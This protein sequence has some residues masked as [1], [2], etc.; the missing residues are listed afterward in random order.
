MNVR[1]TDW[2]LICQDEV[3]FP[4]L[5]EIAGSMLGITLWHESLMW[6]WCECIP[7]TNQADLFNMPA[8]Y[9]GDF[10]WQASTIF[11]DVSLCCV[12]SALARCLSP[13]CQWGVAVE[14]PGREL[15]SVELQKQGHCTNKEGSMTRVLDW[16]LR[17]LGFL[18]YFLLWLRNLSS[19]CFWLHCSPFTK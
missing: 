1:I 3:R 11:P 8:F 4:S 12:G 17:L 2:F 5:V 16:E 18:I 13:R 9:S 15:I 14:E 19:C 6:A 10:G 7:A